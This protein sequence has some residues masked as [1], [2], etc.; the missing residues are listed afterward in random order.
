MKKQKLTITVGIPAHNE[1]ANI[2]HLLDCLYGQKVDDNYEIKNIIVA[3]DGCTD[4]TAL[5]AANKSKI[6]TRI[7]VI[8]DGERLGQSGRLNLFYKNVKEDVFITFDAD[9]LLDNSHVINEIASQF[10]DPKVGLVGGNDTPN[11]PRNIIEKIGAV[12]V[13]SWYKMRKNL[14]NGDTVHNHKGCVSAGRISFLKRLKI[15]KDIFANDDFLYFSCIQLGYKF[16]F[17]EKAIVYYRIPSTFTDYM[18]QTTRFLNLKHRIAS[19]FGDWVYDLYHVPLK[20]KIYGLT[21]TFIFHP[22]LTILAITFQVIQRLSKNHY[23]EN[24]SGISW[25]EIKSSKK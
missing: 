9:T 12:W 4:N 8:N 1:E 13:L 16:R 7:K 11:K 10:E 14:N 2:G 6:D 17:A 20:N 23:T 18:T 24:Y 3:C 19:H 22:L 21:A 15:P 25:K 5:V